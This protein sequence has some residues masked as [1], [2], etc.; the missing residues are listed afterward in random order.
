MMLAHKERH[1]NLTTTRVQQP[2]SGASA[3]RLCRV[4]SFTM[5]INASPD[6]VL[7]EC[8]GIAKPVDGV[9][10]DQMLRVDGP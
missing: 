2:D 3:S 5:S 1:E 9:L 7:G 10:Q 4:L 6:V 8:Q